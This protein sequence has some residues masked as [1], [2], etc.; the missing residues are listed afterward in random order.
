MVDAKHGMEKLDESKG[1]P[2]E[3]GTA[4]AQI[5]FSSTVGGSVGIEDWD[6]D[7]GQMEGEKMGTLQKANISHLG[8]R[9]I[10]DSNRP[11]VGIC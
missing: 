11:W 7:G 4:C 9:K 5:A 6:V 2:N 3:K 1:D 8:K 10:I